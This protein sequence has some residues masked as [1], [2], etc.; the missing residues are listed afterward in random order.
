MVVFVSSF[1]LT[2]PA[3]HFSSSLLRLC[4]I[5]SSGRRLLGV[6]VAA[7]TYLSAEKMRATDI[8]MWPSLIWIWFAQICR[9]YVLFGWKAFFRSIFY[10]LIKSFLNWV[11]SVL[12]ESFGTKC[13]LKSIDI[14]VVQLQ[15]AHCTCIEILSSP[16]AQVECTIAFALQLLIELLLL[17]AFFESLCRHAAVAIARVILIPTDL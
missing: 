14:D 4:Q 7:V 2:F 10:P 6:F 11:C 13:A 5:A 15:F 9:S 3:T 17:L 12:L 8:K 16:A 1:C